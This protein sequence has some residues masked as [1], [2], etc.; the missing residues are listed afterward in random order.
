MQCLHTEKYRRRREKDSSLLRTVVYF[1]N[2]G[3]L[4]QIGAPMNGFAG[5]I[6]LPF[7]SVGYWISSKKHSHIR[8]IYIYLCTSTPPLCVWKHLPDTQT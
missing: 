4:T 2:K 6:H 1:K 5:F 3:M 8:Q 7:T